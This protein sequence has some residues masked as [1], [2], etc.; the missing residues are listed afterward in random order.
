MSFKEAIDY[1]KDLDI[2]LVP[3]ELAEDM[4]HTRQILTGIEKGKSLAVFIGP[5]GGIDESEI[6][7]LKSI[8]ANIITLGRRILRTETA[9]LTV[10]SWLTYILEE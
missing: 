2:L 3:Y 10:L 4:E 9:G 6:E 7:A 8:G 1:A 5:E